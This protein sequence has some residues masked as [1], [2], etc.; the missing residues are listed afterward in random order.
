MMS[1]APSNDRLVVAPDEG[2]A[3]RYVQIVRRPLGDSRRG[4]RAHRRHALCWTVEADDAA[5]AVAMLPRYVATRT[6]AIPVRPVTIPEAAGISSIP[7][8]GHLPE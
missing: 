2:V 3:R 1:S 7:R 4:R 8:G 5:A 6:E